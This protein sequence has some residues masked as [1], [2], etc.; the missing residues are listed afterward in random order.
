MPEITARPPADGGS[1]VAV[2]P[3]MRKSSS[4]QSPRPRDLRRHW[5]LMKM[6]CS[7]I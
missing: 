1:A 3:T 4:V 2:L 6:L 7:F 5:N